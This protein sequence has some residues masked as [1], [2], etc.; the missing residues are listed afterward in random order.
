VFI[1]FK[2]KNLFCL[3]SYQ[4]RQMD[5]SLKRKPLNRSDGDRVEKDCYKK[6]KKEYKLENVAFLITE[7]KLLDELTCPI[8]TSVAFEPIML[9]CQHMV[10]GVCIKQVTK[11]NVVNCPFCRNVYADY[12]LTG[13]RLAKNLLSKLNVKCLS[14]QC[15]WIGPFGEIGEHMEKNCGVLYRCICGTI[16]EKHEKEKHNSICPSYTIECVCYKHIKRVNY[17]NHIQ[18]ECQE[19]TICCNHVHNGCSWKVKLI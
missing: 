14:D 5:F 17:E 9:P 11:D 3:E 2:I 4:S 12:Q 7:R 16:M 15:E 19:T 13:H 1:M 10:C 8:C 6:A 18:T